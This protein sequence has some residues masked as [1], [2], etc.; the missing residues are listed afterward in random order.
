V[1]IPQTYNWVSAVEI[2]FGEGRLGVSLREVRQLDTTP[3]PQFQAEVDDLP[4]VNG[5]AGPAELYNWSVK[6]HKYDHH[7]AH[8]SLSSSRHFGHVILIL[9]HACIS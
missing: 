5:K 9:L 3:Y 4:K 6:P 1:V 8:A 7:E 2:E